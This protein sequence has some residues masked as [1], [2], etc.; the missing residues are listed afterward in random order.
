MNSIQK[1]LK[2]NGYI[3]RQVIM[4]GDIKGLM[5]DTNYD[6]PYPN[7]ET[8]YKH[9]EI[10]SKVKRYKTLQCEARGYF[11]AVLITEKAS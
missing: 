10:F 6:G 9:H 1:W 8:L 3:F 2:D 4:T 7:R 11:T 5:I